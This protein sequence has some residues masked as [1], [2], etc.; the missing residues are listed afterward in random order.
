MAQIYRHHI[1]RRT[2]NA[3]AVESPGSR[4]SS[5]SGERQRQCRLASRWI[6]NPVKSTPNIPF[7][8]EGHS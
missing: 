6:N 7:M 8:V 5:H 1:S 3:V 4:G 2:S